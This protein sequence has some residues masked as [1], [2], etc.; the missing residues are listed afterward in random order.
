MNRHLQRSIE[1]LPLV[2]FMGMYVFSCYIGVALLLASSRFWAWTNLLSAPQLAPLDRDSLTTL[3]ALL[4]GGPLLLWLGY[5]SGLLLWRRCL[6]RYLIFEA[7]DSPNL[8]RPALF[9]YLGTI[10]AAT[11][12]LARADAFS[13]LAAWTDYFTYVRVRFHIFSTLSH[14]EFVNL[15][16][17]L[18]LTSA[19]ILILKRRWW[20][21]VG[22]F[23]VLGFLELSLFQKRPLLTGVLMIA[24]A[25]CA[26]RFLGMAPRRAMRLRLWLP[27][28][29]ALCAALYFLNAALMLRLV[30]SPSTQA[31]VLEKEKDELQVAEVKTGGIP[32]PEAGREEG[33]PAA[34]ADRTPALIVRPKLPA[35]V[36]FDRHIVPARTGQAMALYV[37]FAPLTRTSVPAIAYAQAFPDRIP[38]YHLDLALD[39]LGIGRMPCC[40]SAPL[41]RPERCKRRGGSVSVRTVQPGRH[42]GRAGRVLSGRGSHWRPLVRPLDV[43]PALNQRQPGGESRADTGMDDCHRLTPQRAAGQLWRRVGCSTSRPC[44]GIGALP[45]RATGHA[46]FRRGRTGR[47]FIG[48]RLGGCSEWN[49]RA[50]TKRLYQTLG[51]S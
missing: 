35:V 7:S 46:L 40:Q 49:R 47:D 19:L 25:L 42:S 51:L 21:H 20:Y 36:S 28:G 5:E 29:A 11:I 45:R 17:W 8:S 26:Y 18:P 50:A 13:N 22:V 33:N 38:Y 27:A 16:T 48:S 6:K 24:A 3:L 41:A 9:L 2:V 4:H 32:E 37:L 30:L 23:G 31:L 43:R 14:F 34:P 44:M 12:S 1:R 10:A 39:I 15:Y